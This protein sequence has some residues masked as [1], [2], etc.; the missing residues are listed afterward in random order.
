M[1]FI[2]FYVAKCIKNLTYCGKTRQILLFFLL[3]YGILKKILLY[4]ICMK[5]KTIILSNEN[6][7]GRGIITLLQEED[8]LS[9]RLRLYN[10]EKLNPYC[11]IGIY[12]DGKAYSANLLEKN[13]AYTSSI[14]G[15]FNIDNDFYSAVI[16]TSKDNMVIVS[17]GTYDG[18]FFNDTSVFTHDNPNANYVDVDVASLNRDNSIMTKNNFG[19]FQADKAIDCVANEKS[20]CGDCEHCMYK[21]YFYS[22]QSSKVESSVESAFESGVENLLNKTLIDC[23]KEQ[24]NEKPQTV[25]NSLVSQ[26]KYVFENYPEDERLSGLLPTGKF[27]E[28]SEA[29]SKYSIGALY[30]EGEMKYICYARLVGYADQP[31]AELGEHYQ[32][33]PLDKED[34]LSSGYYIVFQDAKDLKIVEF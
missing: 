5:S 23:E 12:H 1:N 19:N 14:V 20:P 21:E 32:W 11:K 24:A 25:L 10:I 7:K 8:Y 27:V 34:P 33:L 29:D 26:F 13:G 31:P 4:N 22:S 30:E 28:I 15:D 17:G 9:I 18:Y 6:Q 2:I 16:D 3:F